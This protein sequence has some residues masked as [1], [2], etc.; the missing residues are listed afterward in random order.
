MGVSGCTSCQAGGAEA[1]K[2]YDQAFQVR[3]DDEAARNTK[4][5]EAQ[6]ESNTQASSENRP[7]AGAVAGSVINTNA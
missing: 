5:L 3:R 1:L 7:I 2:A 6:K 4:A